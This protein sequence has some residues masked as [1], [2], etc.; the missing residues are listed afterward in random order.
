MTVLFWNSFCFRTGW[1]FLHFTSLFLQNTILFILQTLGFL[2]L[3]ITMLSARSV[4]TVLCLSF[5]YCFTCLVTD[6]HESILSFNLLFLILFLGYSL[7]QGVQ[8]CPDYLR[9]SEPYIYWW[10]SGPHAQFH[11]HLG[12]GKLTGTTRRIL[13][14]WIYKGHKPRQKDT[15]TYV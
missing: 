3:I 5:R 11:Y 10:K 6:E 13:K 9:V 1:R 12:W 14:K 4:I 15:R 8:Y 2:Q 7:Y